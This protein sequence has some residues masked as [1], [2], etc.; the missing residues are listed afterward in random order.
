MIIRKAKFDDKLYLFN[1]VNKLDSLSAKIENKNEITLSDH[2]KWFSERLK[3]SNTHIWIIENEK[4]IP[5]GQIRFQKNIDNYF[6]IDIYLLKDERKK[7]VASKALNLAFNKVNLFPFRAIVK[8]SN[9]RSFSFF[10]KNGFFL[11]S[12]DEFIW[13]LVKE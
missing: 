12:E 11:K 9:I 6:D 8:K 7:G 5:I 2:K 4:K 1:W 10:S 3:D 13:V